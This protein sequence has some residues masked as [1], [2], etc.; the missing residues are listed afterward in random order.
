MEVP[1]IALIAPICRTDGPAGAVC[2][3]EAGKGGTT[4][5]TASGAPTARATK[6]KLDKSVA[7]EIV[8]RK[9]VA[10]EIIVGKIMDRIDVLVSLIRPFT[11]LH[12][13]LAP[14]WLIYKVLPEE[15]LT[16][17]STRN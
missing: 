8:F 17:N 7:G 2:A 10:G 3:S 11:N 5:A 1:L 12:A 15:E 9:T 14:E 16:K 6:N 13:L 4:D